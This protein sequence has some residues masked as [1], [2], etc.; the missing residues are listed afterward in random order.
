VTLTP[1]QIDLL[2]RLRW[3]PF[4]Y[5]HQ[6][7]NGSAAA[8]KSL[9]EGDLVWFDICARYPAIGITADGIEALKEIDNDHG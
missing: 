9:R 8:V 5:M 1:P 4:L 2:K 3:V 6:L 7:W